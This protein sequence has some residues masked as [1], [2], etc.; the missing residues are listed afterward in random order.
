MR[1]PSESMD[2]SRSFRRA[3]PP[4][5]TANISAAGTTT[6]VTRRVMAPV[7]PCFEPEVQSSSALAPA[8]RPGRAC[9]SAPLLDVRGV[10]GGACFLGSGRADLRSPRL[11]VAPR[12]VRVS[13]ALVLLAHPPFQR[14]EQAEDHVGGLVRVTG[15]MCLAGDV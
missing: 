5:A 6:R 12:P 13:P 14:R 7:L 10:P 11:E 15:G 9:S 1:S 3:Q 8:A 4:I 2:C